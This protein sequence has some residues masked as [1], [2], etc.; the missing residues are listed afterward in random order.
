MMTANIGTGIALVMTLQH[1][2]GLLSSLLMEQGSLDLAKVMG[3]LTT[4]SLSFPMVGV[5]NS[6][7]A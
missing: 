4:P 7:M 6:S 5:I 3:A 2:M 1:L